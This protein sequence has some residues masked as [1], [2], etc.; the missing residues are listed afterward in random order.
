MLHIAATNTFIS[1]NTAGLTERQRR[2]YQFLQANPAGVL[3]TITP[4]GEPHGV[5]INFSINKEF[6]IFF[7]TK[8]ATKKY[9]NLKHSDT[10]MLT[11]FDAYKQT[12]AQVAGKAEELRDPLAIN[13]VAGALMSTHLQSGA[14]TLPPISKL[15]AGSY[16][17][18]KIDPVSIHMA[19]YTRVADQDEYTDLFESVESFELEA[20]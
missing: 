2:I 15:R 10:V 18:F 1:S 16:V 14:K 7:L 6:E 4:E 9:R 3:S 5:V 19:I 17:A 20:G 13:G 11:V 8:A 12:T